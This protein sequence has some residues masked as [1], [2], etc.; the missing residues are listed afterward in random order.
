MNTAEIIDGLSKL[1][2]AELSLVHQRVLE[3]EESYVIEPGAEFSAAIEE[4]IQSLATEPTFTVQEV[5][6]EI[7]QWTGKSE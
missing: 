6:Q 2:P 1:N 4:G 3:L 7:A 5:R